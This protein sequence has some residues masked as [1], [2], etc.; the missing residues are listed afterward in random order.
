VEY[1]YKFRLY[2]NGEQINLIERTFGCCRYVYNYYLAKR[3]DVYTTT[4]ETM[5]YYACC[6][7]L[8]LLKKQEETLWLQEVDATALQASVQDL[9]HAYQNF[10]RRV[11]NGETPGYPK[12]KSKHSHKQ[13]YKSKCVGTNIQVLSNAVRLPKLG[14]VKCRI[15]KMVEGRI[16]SATV[17]RSTSGKYYVSLC[18]RLDRDMPKLPDTGA[19]VGLDVGI[20]SFAVSSDG[21]EYANPKYLRQSEKK[22]VRLQRQL[23]RKTKGSANW[24]KARI[25]VARLHE[26]ITN[27]R[28]DMQH[29]L[30]TEIV[31]QYDVICIED[32]A[33]S[34]M[35]K[36]HKLAKAIADASWSEF[37]R[38]LTYKAEWY[39]RKLITV[40]R[41]Y[42][43]SQTCY[44]C[45]ERWPGTKDLSVRQWTCPNCYT[46]LDRDTNAAVNIL[47]EGLRQ[48]A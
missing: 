15:S 41:F 45:G 29:K 21:V 28:K 25:Q 5:N 19:V 1:S 11:K 39:G 23:S 48:F 2:P 16:L 14:K 47:H 22:L 17:S 20:K 46:I 30:S 10:F 40:D 42:A 7:D 12:F 27:Q 32:L 3:Q 35:V 6:K 34:N 37:R 9:D 31:R 33:P 36:N 26:H 18:C 44:F 38:Q 43:S 4:K 13:S 24:N 8:T